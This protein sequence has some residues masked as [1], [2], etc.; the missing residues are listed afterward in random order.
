MRNEERMVYRTGKRTQNT[1]MCDN[2]TGRGGRGEVGGWVG[3]NRVGVRREWWIRQ[4]RDSE[5][6]Q[7]DI[8]ATQ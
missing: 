7:H 6:L 5:T 4:E 8:R 1:A 2:M 3:M